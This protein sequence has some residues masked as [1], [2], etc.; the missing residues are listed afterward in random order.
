MFLDLTAKWNE[1]MASIALSKLAINKLV[2]KTINGEAH[3]HIVVSNSTMSVAG[4]VVEAEA[5]VA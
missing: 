3:T 2:G 4:T 5:F 1:L